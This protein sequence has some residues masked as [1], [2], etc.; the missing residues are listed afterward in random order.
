MTQAQ[1][2]RLHAK[3]QWHRVPIWQHFCQDCGQPIQLTGICAGCAEIRQEVD[4]VIRVMPVILA[5]GMQ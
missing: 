4:S 5:G 1:Q 3:R 2:R